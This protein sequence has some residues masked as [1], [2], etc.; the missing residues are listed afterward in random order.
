VNKE[1]MFAFIGFVLGITLV[2]VV[3]K[4]HF[5]NLQ[6][7]ACKMYKEVNKKTEFNYLNKQFGCE[8]E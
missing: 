1:F 2:S 3:A 8:G 7:V 4:I 6:H 5:D